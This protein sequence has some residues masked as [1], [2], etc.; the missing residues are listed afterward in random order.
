M[1]FELGDHILLAQSFAGWRAERRDSGVEFDHRQTAIWFEQPVDFSDE[2]GFFRDFMQD[3]SDQRQICRSVWNRKNIALDLVQGCSW[4]E[5]T[6]P[7]GV[8]QAIW[9]MLVNVRMS[10]L[11][12]FHTVRSFRC[13]RWF[14]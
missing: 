1:G 14:T 10:G 4:I 6:D 7:I 8:F 11:F 9:C 3:C 12:D 5:L 2:W 13:V